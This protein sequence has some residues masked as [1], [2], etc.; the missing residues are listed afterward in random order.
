L[1]RF[2]DKEVQKDKKLVSY[3][4]VDKQGKPYVK[5]NIG[6]EEKVS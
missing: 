4:I 6:K 2:D 5:V 1:C 3:D